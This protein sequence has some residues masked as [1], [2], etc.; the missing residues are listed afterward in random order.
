MTVKPDPNRSEGRGSFIGY[1]V[2]ARVKRF[3]PARPIAVQDANHRQ[4]VLDEKWR[5]ITFPDNPSCR[6]VASGLFD[7]QPAARAAAWG[8]VALEGS[9]SFIEAKVVPVEV[10]YSW[11]RTYQPEKAEV[12][13][14]WPDKECSPP[15]RRD[16][17]ERTEED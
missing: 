3:A 7:S 6:H 4:V 12:M 9:T 14:M 17:P 13:T 8:L 11:I 15:A 2:Q 16:E 10:A 1:I 5:T